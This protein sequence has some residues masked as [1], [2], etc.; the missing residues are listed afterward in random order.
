[1][2]NWHKADRFVLP[3]LLAGVLLAWPGAAYAQTIPLTQSHI[4]HVRSNCLTAVSSLDQLHRTDALLRVNRGQ[5]Y[6]S[7]STRLMSRLNSRV[8]LNRLDASKLTV[9]SSNYEK[10][11]KSFREHY[12]NYERQLNSTIN[13][14]CREQPQRFYDMVV[15][16]GKRRQRVNVDVRQIHRYLDDYN[17]AFAALR[18]EYE[19]AVKGLSI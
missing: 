13:I 14:N 5:L 1:M 9:A 3:L 4:A 8:A 18:S 19:S 17:K 6:E 15:E 12:I 10:A 16:T 11:L 7:I 2:A